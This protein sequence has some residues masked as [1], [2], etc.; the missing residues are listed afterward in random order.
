[1]ERLRLANVSLV[2]C[3][4]HLE[5]HHGLAGLVDTLT[6]V[7]APPFA[8]SATSKHIPDDLLEMYM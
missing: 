3:L 2:A 7:K 6:S 4:G 1:M 5:V 8:M